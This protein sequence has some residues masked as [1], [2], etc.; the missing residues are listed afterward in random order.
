ME[1]AWK[2]DV[3][4][5]MHSSKGA[6]MGLYRLFTGADGESHIDEL[7][8]EDHPELRE[9][10]AT[11]GIRLQEFPA[12]QF[13]DWHPAPR[14]QWVIILSGELEIGL[15]DGT[16]RRFGPGDAR[17]VEDTTGRGHTTRTLGDRT[18]L[19]MAVHVAG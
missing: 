18:C 4:A 13:I 7:K 8:P 6:I 11:S 12:K 3:M 15:G 10:Q 16:F 9:I 14:R 5:L 19:A 2:P 17:L 1:G